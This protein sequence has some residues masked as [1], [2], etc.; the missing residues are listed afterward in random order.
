MKRSNILDKEKEFEMPSDLSAFYSA[1]QMYLPVLISV[2]NGS[3]LCLKFR[4]TF[5]KEQKLEL[6]FSLMCSI[7]AFKNAR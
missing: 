6:H 2:K 7:H 3:V 5:I 1:N 4:K